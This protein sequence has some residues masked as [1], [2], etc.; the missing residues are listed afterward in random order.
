MFENKYEKLFV[1][2]LILLGVFIVGVQVG[3]YHG[4]EW[5]EQGYYD[6]TGTN[7]IYSCL[8]KYSWH[9]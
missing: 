9:R 2:L 4:R 5:Q 7:Y 3:I 6:Q 1:I 8:E